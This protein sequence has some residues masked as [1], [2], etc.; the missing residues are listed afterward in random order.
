VGRGRKVRKGPGVSNL[1]QGGGGKRI[2]MKRKVGGKETEGERAKLS[3]YCKRRF[4]IMEKRNSV[5]PGGMT[6]TQRGEKREGMGGKKTIGL[7]E[8]RKVAQ[9]VNKERA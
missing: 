6:S 2:E 5:T 3:F 7:E 8:K 4:L 1:S 9:F